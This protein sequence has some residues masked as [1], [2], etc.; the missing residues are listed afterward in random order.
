MAPDDEAKDR[1]RLVGLVA[2]AG[3]PVV[4]AVALGLSLFFPL[5]PGQRVLV[6]GGGGVLAALALIAPWVLSRR[7]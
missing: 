4:L 6:V 2:I 7:S 3:V 5:S 1:D